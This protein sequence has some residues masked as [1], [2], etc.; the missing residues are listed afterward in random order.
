MSRNG[1][2][3]GE[4]ALFAAGGGEVDG[5]GEEFAERPALQSDLRGCC[6]RI[7]IKIGKFDTNFDR[8]QHF[9]SLFFSY[10]LG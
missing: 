1:E 5:A 2:E 6:Y 8:I 3:E 10:I 9:Q 7:Q 4:G